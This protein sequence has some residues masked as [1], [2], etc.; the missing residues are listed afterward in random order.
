MS[1]FHW[2]RLGGNASS[3]LD[4]G[5]REL[6]RWGGVKVTRDWGISETLWRSLANEETMV[7]W[8]KWEKVQKNVEGVNRGG[9][10]RIE[11]GGKGG[12]CFLIG[13]LLADGIESSKNSSSVSRLA[14]GS[15][16]PLS[17]L[18]ERAMVF[19]S[20]GLSSRLS[21]Q[22]GSPAWVLAPEKVCTGCHAHFLWVLWFSLWI[23]TVEMLL[24]KLVFSV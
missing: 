11:F 21:G 22:P 6:R 23:R 1:S 15:F 18:L 2:R 19:G 14:T 8:D 4:P 13:Q 17:V 10:L 12:D 9:W 7:F 20:T 3:D 16:A 5:E 24:R